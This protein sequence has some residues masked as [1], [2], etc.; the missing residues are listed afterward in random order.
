MSSL[1]QNK[2]T[3]VYDKIIEEIYN[4]EGD[5]FSNYLYYHNIQREHEKDLRMSFLFVND[6]YLLKMSKF[7]I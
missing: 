4:K 5:N 2:T 6:S 3:V 7:F 1:Y